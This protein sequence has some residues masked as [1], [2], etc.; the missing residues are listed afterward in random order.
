M[1]RNKRSYRIGVATSSIFLLPSNIL[2][3]DTASQNKIQGNKAMRKFL[4]STAGAS[5]NQEL[6]NQ[7]ICVR[8][9]C[10]EL[11]YKVQPSVYV[12]VSML[13]VSDSEAMLFVNWARYFDRLANPQVQMP[14]IEKCCPTLYAVMMCDDPDG[15][16]E[17]DCKPDGTMYH[18]FSL[19]VEITSKRA[20]LEC[21]TPEMFSKG[22]LLANKCLKM[23]MELH[24]NPPSPAWKD[25]LDEVWN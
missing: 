4:S 9:N 15:V 18:G 16:Y 2:T 13:H 6:P 20:L 23:Y 25:G 17:C 22:R 19:K 12:I 24:N 5:F 7:T 14:R 21:I 3:F 11:I 1:I 8:K 10:V